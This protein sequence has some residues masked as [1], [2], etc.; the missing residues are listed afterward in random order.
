MPFDFNAAVQA[1][2][3]MQPGLRRMA[4]GAAQLTPSLPGSRTLREKLA[5]LGVHASQA[6]LASPGF[7]AAPA[8]DALCTQARHEQPQAWAWDGVTAHAPHL[9]WAVR[10]DAVLPLDNTQ[11]EIGSCLAALPAAWRLGGL[12]ALAFAEDFAIVD[13]DS[14]CIPWLAVCLPSHWAPEAK[15]GR[16]FTEVHAPVADNATLLAASA[17]LIRLVTGEDR[18]ERFVW[19]ITQHPRLHAHP[20]RA[21]REPWPAVATP[22]ALAARA[23]WRTEHQTFI[24]VPALR[25]AVFTIHVE[26]QT[27][28]LAIATR[29]RAARL[30]DA[31]ASMSPAVLA[32]RGLS[33]V[34]SR[35]L[36]WLDRQDSA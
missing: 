26:V 13:A 6:L 11:P 18:W 21:A 4:A 24:P 17:H 30:R 27:L 7:D 16:H 19:T 2:F 22:E 25:Q 34:Q 28:E 14:G 10:G 8:L 9:G 23:Y 32:Y 12:L 5:V 31:L 1:P 35:L 36:T 15:V 33:D 3:R 20:Q 29:E